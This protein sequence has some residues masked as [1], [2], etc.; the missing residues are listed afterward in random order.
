MKYIIPIIILSVLTSCSKDFLE[1]KSTQSVDQQQIFES[2]TSAMMAVNGIHRLMYKSGSNAAQCGYGTYMLWCDM[3]GEDLV[4][5]KGNAQWESQARWM[6]HRN[7]TSSH[8]KFLFKMFYTIISNA[9]MILANIDEA[10][11][12]DSERGLYKGTGSGIQGIRTLLPSTAMGGEI[13][14]G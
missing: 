1:T 3:L 7:T 8:N 14:Q 11:G 12:P 13:L 4:Y 9:N 10:D 6:L 5:T 2:T